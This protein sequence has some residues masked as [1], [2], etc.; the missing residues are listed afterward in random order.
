MIKFIKNWTLPISMLTGIIGYF[1]YVNIPFLNVTKLFVN[2][3]VN[4]VQPVLLFLMLFLTFCK[5][6]P[7]ELRPVRWH[8]WL[9]LV[10]VVSFSALCLVLHLYPDTPWRLVLECAMLSLICPTATAGAVVTTKLGGNAAGITTYTILINL[11]VAIV[12]PLLLPIAHPQEGVTFLPAFFMIIR[13]VFPL[14]ICP[15]LA[16]WLVRYLTPRFHQYL[17]SFK[18]LAFYLWAVALVIAIAVTCKAVVHSG[19][20]VWHIMGIGISTLICCVAQFAIGKKIGTCYGNRIEAG[21][22]L[23]QKSTVF[24]IWLGYMFLTPATAV[25]GGFY[26]I[27]HNTINSYQLW[28]KRKKDLNDL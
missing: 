28:K 24:I 13:E 20:S 16:A 10:Q 3:F 4:I 5:V 22:S 21:Q 18:D 14:L 15:L 11:V 2:E 8:L 19:E 1:V 12:I 26:S 17:L 9:M 6:K 25:A 23:G 27:W 7:S